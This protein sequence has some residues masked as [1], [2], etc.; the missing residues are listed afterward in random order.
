MTVTEPIHDSITIHRLTGSIGAE[1]A[2]VNLKALDDAQFA[3]IKS[4]LHDHLMLVFRDQFL[5][6]NEHVAFARRWG[7]PSVSP[8]VT[9][10][11]G[12]PEVLP[13]VNRGQAGTVTNNWHA[14]SC[15]LP[16]PPSLTINSARDVPIGGDT[17]WSNQYL[18]YEAL[19][20]GMRDFLAG[21][22]ICFTGSRL[23]ALGGADEVPYSYHPII[24]VHPETGRKSLFIGLP[25]D[26]VTHF[27]NMTQEESLPLL[28]Y[29]YRHSYEP[30]RVYRHIF[31]NGDVVMWDNRCTMH[32]A[33][34]D[35]GNEATRD[36]H[37]ISIQ[38]EKPTG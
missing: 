18:A 32:Y 11:P 15:F 34:H 17:M 6:V 22:R 8:F 20:D 2:G 4:A 14:D 19:S 21:R 10:L 37:R 30:D 13:L 9:Y 29:L 28:Q 35:Y 12:H 25:G 7:A 36:L 3:I 16:E 33:V 1:L 31:R 27:E 26:S 24:R 23:A 5:S 38:G